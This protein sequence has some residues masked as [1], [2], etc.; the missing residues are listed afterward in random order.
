MVEMAIFGTLILLIFGVLIS[1]VQRFNDQQYTQME[2]F[3]IGL[4][5]ACNYKT[6]TGAGASVQVTSLQNRRHSDL[7]SGFKKG[8]EQAFSASSSVLW[9]VPKVGTSGKSAMYYKINEDLTEI[10]YRSYISKGEEKDY[11]FRTEQLETVQDTTFNEQLIK[12]ETPADIVT[13]RSS[14]LGETIITTIPYTIR[15]RDAKADEDYDDDNNAVVR[16]GTL[17]SQEQHLYRDK[18][19]GQYKYSVHAPA[20]TVIERGRTWE[21]DF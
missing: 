19:D 3:R 9:S 7:S 12:S 17:I 20:G 16:S 8:A 13:K 18:K 10:D 1:Y 4:E 5:K 14:R 11:S 6:S 21:T 2:A 15:E